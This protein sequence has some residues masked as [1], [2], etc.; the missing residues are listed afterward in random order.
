MGFREIS[1]Q[2]HICSGLTDELV[3]VNLTD[4]TGA[5]LANG[6]YLVEVETVVN[7]VSNK[8]VMKCLLLR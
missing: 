1:R 7:G 5:T 4:L 3:T 2:D 6:V 8:H